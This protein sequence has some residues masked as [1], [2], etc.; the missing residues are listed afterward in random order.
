MISCS[1]L[2]WL[3]VSFLFA[4]EIFVYR[5]VHNGLLTLLNISVHSYI[6]YVVICVSVSD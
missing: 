4:S 1:K 2:S 5:I 3:S 6:L